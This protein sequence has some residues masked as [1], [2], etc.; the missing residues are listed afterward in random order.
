MK[1]KFSKLMFSVVTALAFTVS[2]AF[3]TTVNITVNTANWGA[4]VS[5]DLTD[6]SGTILASGSGYG[7]YATSV[8]TI[9]AP[10]G[11]YNMNM[12]DSFGD[13][14]NGGTYS[15][16]DSASGQIYATGGLTGGA[17]GTDVFG[18]GLWDVLILTLLTTTLMQLLMTEV[19]LM[20]HLLL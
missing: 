7:N 3:A 5:W 20:L 17:Y 16:A 14:W 9:T 2:T 8:T 13:G 6:G 15:I 4:E 19:V 12:Y 11:C 10:N 18:G 1:N